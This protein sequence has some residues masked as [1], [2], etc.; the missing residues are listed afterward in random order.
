MPG[1]REFQRPCATYCPWDNQPNVS[2]IESEQYLRTPKKTPPIN[3]EEQKVD[4]PK[5][6]ATL[7]TLLAEGRIVA[8]HQA[9]EEAPRLRRSHV[10][11]LAKEIGWNNAAEELAHEGELIP[12]KPQCDTA[13]T[14]F[15]LREAAA[16]RPGTRQRVHLGGCSAL[17]STDSCTAI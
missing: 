13:Y 6:P 2:D 7:D 9:N 1:H 17:C 11:R 3:V 10:G 5:L 8:R 12:P 4:I 14:Y 15:V 16:V